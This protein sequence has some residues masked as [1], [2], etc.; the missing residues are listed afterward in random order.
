[1]W[2]CRPLL[3][4]EGG[5]GRDRR[6][7]RGR[8]RQVTHSWPARA[9]IVRPCLKHIKDQT[10]QK[11]T[12]KTQTVEEKGQREG[13]AGKSTAAVDED[14]AGFLAPARWSTTACNSSSPGIW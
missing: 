14:W 13:S 7:T 3:P 1:M 2:A 9:A 12:T 10:I 6:P 4:E 8:K 11:A 5:E